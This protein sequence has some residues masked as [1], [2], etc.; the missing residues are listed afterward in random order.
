M[1]LPSNPYAAVLYRVSRWFTWKGLR[2]FLER[3]YG[4]I[5]PGARVL[6][7]GAGGRFN[8]LLRPH[9][10]AR[11]FAVTSLDIDLQRRPAIVGDLCASPFRAATFDAIVMGEVLEHVHTPHLAI[12]DV[13]RL[14]KA[15]GALILTTPFI[16]PIHDRPRDYYR[17]TRYGLEFLLRDFRDVRITPRNSWAEAINALGVRIVL[18][19]GLL[20]QL[21]APLFLTAA[22]AGLPFAWVLGRLIPTDFMTI[23]YLVTARK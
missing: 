11:P 9:A 14:L 22:V 1:K 12:A 5:P 18:E 2:G 4:R 3:E 16:F 10:G 6:S 7:V 20:A 17:Y 21:A 15:G 19:R 13:H 23:G 8:D